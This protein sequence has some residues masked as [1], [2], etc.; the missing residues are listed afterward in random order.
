MSSEKAAG[1]ATSRG[2]FCC[3]KH[4]KSRLRVSQEPSRDNL[5]YYLHID[6]AIGI[7]VGRDFSPRLAPRSTDRPLWRL[8]RSS[9]PGLRG[10]PFFINAFPGRW[11]RM[12]DNFPACYGIGSYMSQR[13]ELNRFLQ[14]RNIFTASVNL[15]TFEDWK[16]AN[17]T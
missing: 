15:V 6:S 1:L 12:R 16:A 7:I 14:N 4:E 9:R 5:P 11:Q 10:A 3:L 2:L 8:Q 17:F 13:D